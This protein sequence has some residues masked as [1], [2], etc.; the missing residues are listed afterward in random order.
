MS[1][2]SAQNE[3]LWLPK[4]YQWAFSSS[5]F[6][7]EYARWMVAVGMPSPCC[8]LRLTA[9]KKKWVAFHQY[10]NVS[11]Q[12]QKSV[13][14]FSSTLG[15]N[16]LRWVCISVVIKHPINCSLAPTWQ[17]L[18]Q[19]ALLFQSVL[20]Y[21]L[22]FVTLDS[23]GHSQLLGRGFPIWE[24]L[25]LSLEESLFLATCRELKMKKPAS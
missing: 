4:R 19:S 12:I 1:N 6:L 21:S 17:A 25:V 15:W 16:C 5:F 9:Q 11:N 14:Q 18:G 3:N 20:G 13:K 7:A 22:L 10:G 2:N 23:Q 24:L 8:Y